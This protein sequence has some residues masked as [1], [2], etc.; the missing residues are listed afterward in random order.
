MLIPSHSSQSTS[1]IHKRDHHL[2]SATLRSSLTHKPAWTLESFIPQH[3]QQQQQ[4]QQQTPLHR[5]DGLG[6]NNTTSYYGNY[7]YNVYPHYYNSYSYNEYPR[8]Y[9]YPAASTQTTPPA[10]TTRQTTTPD[11]T[12]TAT[13]EPT[14]PRSF[15]AS[16]KSSPSYYR[17]FPEEQQQVWGQ[18]CEYQTAF[19]YNRPHSYHATKNF[20]KYNSFP[21][22]NTSSVVNQ[23]PFTQE[24]QQPRDYEIQ[25]NNNHWCTIVETKTPHSSPSTYDFLGSVYNYESAH[26]QKAHALRGQDSGNQ[27]ALGQSRHLDT[28]DR[29]RKQA[30]PESQDS[31]WIPENSILEPQQHQPHGHGTVYK[32]TLGYNYYATLETTPP[33]SSMGTHKSHSSAYQ[34]TAYSQQT[35]ASQGHESGYKTAFSYDLD[36][37]AALNQRGYHAYPESHEP[38]WTYAGHFPQQQQQRQEQQQ[39]SLLYSNDGASAEH[40][41][42]SSF[43]NSQYQ[44]YY[45]ANGTSMPHSLADAREFN[46]IQSSRSLQQQQQHPPYGNS[47]ELDSTLN[48]YH[49]RSSLNPA[50]YRSLI[51]AHGTG[52]TH[53]GSFSEQQQQQQQ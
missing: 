29:A 45:H 37:H 51:I 35:H 44:S 20:P 11:T 49:Y 2:V 7:Y 25:S 47:T 22:S 10:S 4:Q 15:A 5:N 24:Q 42:T 36:H 13:T 32:T 41:P 48:S 46:S 16:L 21:S 40:N 3:E 27:T 38:Q 12:T 6:I 43:N 30:N 23:A 50:E 1:S 19:S 9:F 31:H 39:R 53:Q 14:T 8:Y 52:I 28:T 34:S 33:R 26:S 18:A 17:L